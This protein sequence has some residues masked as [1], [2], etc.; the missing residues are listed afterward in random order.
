MVILCCNGNDYWPKHNIFIINPLVVTMICVSWSW[1]KWHLHLF[2]VFLFRTNQKKN[3]TNSIYQIQSG[4]CAQMPFHLMISFCLL[5]SFAIRIFLK[6]N[7]LFSI[8]WWG[9]NR[10]PNRLAEWYANCERMLFKINKKLRRKKAHTVLGREYQLV[11]VIYISYLFFFP[12]L[13]L[14]LPLHSFE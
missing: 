13:S 11:C 5:L 2:F 7:P 3:K 10:T 9:K 8:I 1:F 14:L 12:G 4:K 6:K